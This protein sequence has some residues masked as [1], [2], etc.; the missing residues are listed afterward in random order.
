MKFDSLV[1]MLSLV[2]APVLGTMAHGPSIQNTE[3]TGSQHTVILGK[4]AQVEGF[5]A[6]A[7][8]EEGPLVEGLRNGTWKR[9][10]ANGGLRSEIHYTDDAPFGDYKLFT[11]DGLL[12]EEGRWEHGVNVGHLRRYWPNGTIQQMLTF[13]KNGVGQGQQR[14]FHNNGQLE[15]LVELYD[16]QEQ[17]DLVRL[18]RD[19][20][21]VKRTTYSDGRIVQRSE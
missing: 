19:G 2:A 10:H 11:D 20:Q 5:P 4:D 13:D 3:P 17:G 12:F 21:V 16:G 6:D 18:D 9:Y 15:M 8:Y 14:Y 1:L 7:I